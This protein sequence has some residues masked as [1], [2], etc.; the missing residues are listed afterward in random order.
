M[1]HL[2]LDISMLA[3][4]PLLSS[5]TALAQDTTSICDPQQYADLQLEARQCVSRNATRL[6]GTASTDDQ[7]A[8]AAVEECASDHSWLAMVDQYC[9]YALGSAWLSVNWRED[10]RRTAIAAIVEAHAEA[11]QK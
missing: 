8:T 5:G 9:G 2:L 3:L 10:M 11:G 1:R 7:I 4:A 6:A